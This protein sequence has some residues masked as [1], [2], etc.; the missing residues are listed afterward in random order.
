MAPV[1][2]PPA[3]YPRCLR[4]GLIEAGDADGWE[5]TPAHRYPRCLRLGL[6]EAAPAR[7]SP[8]GVRRYP[9]G[10]RL[11]LIEA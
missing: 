7:P 1:S 9:R 10:L 2:D 11:G 6:I 8:G 3:T 4:L 5:V